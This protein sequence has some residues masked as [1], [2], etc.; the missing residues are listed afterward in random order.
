MEIFQIV[1]LVASGA[2]L[3]F[4]GMGRLVKP[5]GS[6]CL[7]TYLADAANDLRSDPDLISEMRGAGV[8]TAVFGA[9]ILLGVVSPDFRLTS[10][11]CATVFYLGYAF[12][13]GFSWIKDGKPT[14]RTRLG[15]G[16]E[17]V[18]GTLSA[19]CLINILG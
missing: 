3:V 6:V 15:F 8:I 9:I 16:F 19:I 12:G 10:F 18:L 17:A 2:L 11:V 1:V 4:A 5:E 7:D 13:R 14:K